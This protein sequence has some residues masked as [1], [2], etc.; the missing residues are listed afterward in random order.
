MSYKFKTEVPGREESEKDT[1]LYQFSAEMPLNKSSIFNIE[2]LK[3]ALIKH[4]A[5]LKI[6]IGGLV[7]EKN[8]MY[9]LLNEQDEACNTPSVYIEVY[10]NG[11]ESQIGNICDITDIYDEW[12][13][14]KVSIV[15]E[16]HNDEDLIEHLGDSAN[17]ILSAYTAYNELKD[18]S[19]GVGKKAAFDPR[20]LYNEIIRYELKK[21]GL[22]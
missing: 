16:N 21:D 11:I 19:E 6:N 7:L 3:T 15:F 10:V 8:K 14:K 9:S 22:L 20:E 2:P 13:E 5:V 17:E 1:L 4:N 18:Q 12:S